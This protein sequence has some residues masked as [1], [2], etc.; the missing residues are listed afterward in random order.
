MMADWER[1]PPFIP[2]PK[3]IL[4]KFEEQTAILSQQG[5]TREAFQEAARKKIAEKGISFVLA[6]YQA[7]DEFLEQEIKISGVT[8]A[9]KKGCSQ[10]CDTLIISTEM[11]IDE[12]IRFVNNIPRAVRI[13]L[14]RRA[15]SFAREWRDYTKNQFVPEIDPFKSFKDW[16]GRPCPFLNEDDGSCSIYPVR[17][18]DCRRLTSLTPCTADMKTLIPCD[19][20]HQGPGHYRFQCEI[21]A[22]NMILEEQGG[23]FRLPDPRLS[24]VTP[25]HHWLWIKEREFG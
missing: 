24:P 2:I 20:H 11:E 3:E 14:I 10:C 21:W 15:L 18:M 23:K 12:V 6:V 8:L 22:T 16:K 9:C 19:L 17:I 4:A 7:F 1:K 25:V 13:P 5:I